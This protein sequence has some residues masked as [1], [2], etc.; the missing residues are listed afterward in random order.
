MKTGTDQEKYQRWLNMVNTVFMKDW[1]HTDGGIFESP[2][3]TLHD[4]SAADLAQLDR[5]EK[6][7]FFIV[8]GKKEEKK[9]SSFALKDELYEKFVKW[10]GGRDLLMTERQDAIARILLSMPIA[11]GKSWLIKQLYQFDKAHNGRKPE[12]RVGWF[13]VNLDTDR[14]TINMIEDVSN[15]KILE[16]IPAGK[17]IKILMASDIFDVVREGESAPWYY[18]SIERDGHWVET[19]WCPGEAR[20]VAR[21][22]P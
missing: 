13:E 16:R 18:V 12:R 4:L 1:Q 20:I 3:G 5:I 15:G 6:E 14:H 2:S 17:Y 7:G 21:R 19:R 22:V 8:G 10:L 9:R 11:F